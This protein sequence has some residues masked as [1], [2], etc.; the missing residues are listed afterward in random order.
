VTVRERRRF[1]DGALDLAGG[2]DDHG[3]SA[4]LAAQAELV[5]AGHGQPPAAA[6]RSRRN[7][8]ARGRTTSAGPDRLHSIVAQPS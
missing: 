7:A 1:E 2:G 4:D 5:E 3:S 6:I 8:A